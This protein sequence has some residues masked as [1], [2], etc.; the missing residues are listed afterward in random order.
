MQ[1]GHASPCPAWALG[2]GLAAGSV[3]HQH[4]LQRAAVDVAAQERARSSLTP[5]FGHCL[6][7]V[8][9]MFKFSEVLCR[10]KGAKCSSLEEMRRSRLHG[11]FAG[12]S[13][14]QL[15]QQR[16]R[17]TTEGEAQSA[18]ATTVKDDWTTMRR[19]RRL[20][21]AGTSVVLI[22][23]LLLYITSFVEGAM[24]KL[25]AHP[26][27]A[28]S[29]AVVLMIGLAVGGLHTVA[30]P[31]HLA[32]LAPLVIGKGRSVFAAFGLGALWGSGHA[33]GQLIIG[34]GCLA[35]KMGLLQ[36]HVAQALEQTSGLL[37]GASLIAIGLLG[38]KEARQYDTAEE[39]TGDQNYGWA[40]YA[41][42][43]VHG[44][45]LDAIIFI[46]PAFSLPR[47]SAVIHVLGVV[48]GTLFSMG[49]YTTVLS[50]F[51]RKSP[52][53]KLISASASSISLLLG[54]CIMMS[55]VGIDLPLPGL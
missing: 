11:C 6:V 34:I 47:F 15:L 53:L 35:V 7:L 55:C 52:K 45:S 13:R 51:F 39:A 12:R 43:V 19:V 10:R 14:S 3:R 2:S 41:T 1:A 49:C 28:K 17:P 23:L 38:F 40:T 48:F 25:F 44:L 29:P 21:K 42:G 9:S 31:D 20:L 50:L 22:L 26:M 36:M 24:H 54:I 27:T 4:G 46:L 37:V 16:R 30:G 33:T 32:A 18:G 5:R 8:G